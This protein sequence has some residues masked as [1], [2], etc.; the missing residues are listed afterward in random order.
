MEVM[1]SEKVNKFEDTVGRKNFWR[2]DPRGI[3]MEKE[4]R[5]LGEH[6]V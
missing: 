2:Q 1:E 5:G 4:E 6:N 3:E